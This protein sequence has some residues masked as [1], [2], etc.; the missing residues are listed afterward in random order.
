MGLGAV[1]EI[2][3][4]KIKPRFDATTLDECK[5]LRFH[6][7]ANSDY[8]TRCAGF[9]FARFISL[10]AVRVVL[11]LLFTHT[12]QFL[13]RCAHGGGLFGDRDRPTHG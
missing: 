4:E 7:P 9:S 1:E 12:V 3:Y 13:A 10:P 8:F 5:E 11:I 2:R 6:V